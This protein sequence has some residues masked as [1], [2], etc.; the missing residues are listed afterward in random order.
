[1]IS[2]D[3][4]TVKNLSGLPNLR[5]LALVR[6]TPAESIPEYSGFALVDLREKNDLQLQ[7][8]MESFR[9]CP[10]LEYV[11]IEDMPRGEGPR[12]YRKMF[13]SGPN[14]GP[15]AIT[16]IQSEEFFFE[17]EVGMPWWTVYGVQ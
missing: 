8:T 6:L 10:K 7:L 15:D 12:R 3:L 4:R 1:L 13:M 16:D 2:W 14:R 17:H 11:I 9:R 5:V